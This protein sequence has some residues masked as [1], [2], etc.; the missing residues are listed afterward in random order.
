MP[1]VLH[2]TFVVLTAIAAVGLLAGG[3]DD[4]FIDAYYWLRE[5][6]RKLFLRRAI[7]AIPQE[8]LCGPAEKSIAIWIPAWREHDV[9]DKMLLHSIDTIKYEK[10]AIFVGTYPND[11][12]TQAA[13]DSISARYQNVTK[14]VCLKPGP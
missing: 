2:Q 11:Q 1:P 8:E 4:V 14:I 13:V 3:I 7:R 10:Y 5:L 6:Y 12:T 9:I